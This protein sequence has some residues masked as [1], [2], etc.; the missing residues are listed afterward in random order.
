MAN[1]VLV[2]GLWN[3]GWSMAAVAK[4][5]RTR[6][7][8]VQVFSYPTR[9]DSIEGHADEL[10]AFVIKSG[11]GE[12][13]YVGHSMG[14]LVILKMMSKYDDLPP[15]RIVMM[16]T[17][18]KGSNVVKR[19][20]VLPAQKILFGKVRETL[21]KGFEHTPRGHETGMIRG[22][23]SLGLGRLTGSH[24]GPNDGTVLVSET[25]LEGLTDFID[26]PVAH[27]E[28]LMSSEVVAQLEQ[29]VLNGKFNHGG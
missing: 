18:I 17:P 21:L 25:E 4:R 19:L 12:L 28:M 29:F 10:H 24:L 7:H 1:I 2:H 23:R 3:R 14:G 15:G 16:G 26:L 22:T 11:I 5:L 9:S 13:N 6:G 20:E 27:T 8:N